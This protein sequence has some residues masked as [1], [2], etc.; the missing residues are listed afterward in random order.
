MLVVR[1]PFDHMLGREDEVEDR[2]EVRNAV[3]PQGLVRGGE[4][5]VGG[6]SNGCAGVGVVARKPARRQQ[7]TTVADDAGLVDLGTAR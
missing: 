1:M 6:A 4:R 2:P 3:L 7:T 5:D